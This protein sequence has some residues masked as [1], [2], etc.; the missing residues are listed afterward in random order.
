MYNDLD[1]N[2]KVYLLYCDIGNYRH[3]VKESV[4]A[5]KFFNNLDSLKSALNEL[6]YI[7]Y[8]Y[9][10]PTPEKEL[11]D[12]RNNEQKIIQDFLSR[13]WVKV[14]SEAA[15]LKTDKGK[16]KKI[17]SFFD[18]LE[19]YKDRFSEETLNLLTKAQKEQPDYTLKRQS[20]A[21]KDK[22]F[23]A[24]TEKL[25][26]MQN[27]I[28]YNIEQSNGIFAW[29]YQNNYLLSR[30]MREEIDFDIIYDIIRLM[31]SG[32]DHKKA[33]RYL[34]S[35]FEIDTK[36]AAQLYITACGIVNSHRSVLH[37]QHLGYEQYFIITNGAPCPICEKLKNRVFNFSD[38][39]IG[40]NYP[41][42]CK[43]NCSTTEIYIERDAESHK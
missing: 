43:H 27:D 11:S 16:D 2:N 39:K 24:K 25:L 18:S 32:I 8:S 23:L 6:T 33:S 30:I 12:L 13:Y 14:V 9:Y 21:E 17:K 29:F 19:P 42:F 36:Y 26:D 41:P 7:D 10:E 20:K 35:K 3:W 31:L 22:L 15:Q 37:Y 28:M 38:A 5:E 34:R 4:N 1:T 40:V